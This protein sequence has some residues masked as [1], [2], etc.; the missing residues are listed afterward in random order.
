M[1][2]PHVRG[3][4]DKFHTGQEAA[5]PECEVTASIR[6]FFCRW[7]APSARAAPPK[8]SSPEAPSPGPPAPCLHL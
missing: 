7:T 6:L 1:G 3:D 2:G 4:N 8:G 5:C